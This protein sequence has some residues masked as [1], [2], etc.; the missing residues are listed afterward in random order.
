MQIDPS[1]SILAFAFTCLVI[2]LTPGPNMAYLALLS[3]SQGRRAGFVAALGT[4]LGLLIVGIAAALGVAAL[5]TSSTWLYQ[6]L[7]WAGGL[8]LLWLAWETWVGESAPDPS[9]LQSGNGGTK[10]FVRGLLTNLLNP[11]AAMFYIAILPGFIEPLRPALP[12][13]LL[14]S[15]IYVCIATSIHLSIVA[16]AGS[17]RSLLADPRRTETVRRVFA[18]LLA[19]IALWMMIV[20]RR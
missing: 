4:G 3:A 20:T 12:Q 9:E 11:K 19:A 5:V 2:E 1:A 15:V 17:A 10:Y 6:G 18:L 7:R 13:T 16:I 14:L 8:Y